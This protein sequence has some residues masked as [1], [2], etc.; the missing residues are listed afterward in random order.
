VFAAKVELLR[1]R[2]SALELASRPARLGKGDLAR[3]PVMLAQSRSPLRSETAPGERAHQNGK[4]HN[5]RLAAC[6]LDGVVLGQGQV[7][8][9][10]RQIGRAS[11]ARGYVVGR[12][13]KQGCLVP[14][15]G[16]GLC[17]LS[18]ALYALALETGCEIVERHAH[19]RIMPGSDAA[20]G[21]DATVAWNY[22]DLRFRATHPILIEAKLTRDELVL[23]F[24]SAEGSSAVSR[25]SERVTGAPAVP[26]AARSC[27]TCNEVDCFRHEPRAAAQ[28]KADRTAFL[29]DEPWPEHLQWVEANAADRDI[30]GAPFAG[31]PF[32]PRRRRWNAQGF[33][34]IGAAPLAG[35][36]RSW[37]LRRSASF[38]AANRKAALLGAER[39]SRGLASLAGSDVDRLVVAQSFA[40]FLWRDGHFGGRSVSILMTRLPIT[41]L[42]AKLDAGFAR[43]P[44]RPRLA[45]YRA[46]AWLGEAEAQALATAERIVTPHAAVARLFPG[47]AV[48]L[49]WRQPEQPS[50]DAKAALRRVVF[51]GPTAARKGAFELRDAARALDLEVVL[52]GSE[53]EGPSFWEG[54]RTLRPGAGG[55]PGWLEGAA[56]VVQ[57]A[58]IEDQPRRLLAA[59]SAG[60]PVVATSACGLEPQPGLEI[61]PED[62]A[63]ALT[64][65]LARLV[66]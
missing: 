43:H 4:I 21:R 48:K 54:V 13:L 62:D 28:A 38:P 25:A 52:L 23:R 46:P 42:Q 35:L 33:E 58:I 49:D 39:V 45:D 56:A 2:R 6:A 11:R 47:R 3:F 57:P 41:A 32:E 8:S 44:D 61:V 40:P 66:G 16:G 37:A 29:L 60:M 31:L 20:A 51:P 34:R 1:L 12:M 17:Q 18:N 55:G 24:R 63:Q 59:L 65:A 26:R 36:R 53:L 19:S 22:V 7:F 10:W 5:L 64:E 9:F 15:V 50:A 30:L 14:A 27:A